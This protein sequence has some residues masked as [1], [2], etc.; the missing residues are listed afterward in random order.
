VVVVP[1]PVVVAA[2]KAGAL[3]C[4]SSVLRSLAFQDSALEDRIL[5]ATTI[6]GMVR[7]RVAVWFSSR[8]SEGAQSVYQEVQ[9][10]TKMLNQG[11][12]A[13]AR[14]RTFAAEIGGHRHHGV[15]SM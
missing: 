2:C 9:K 12:L 7:G 6:H 5:Y 3:Q 14:Q 4:V 1:Q 13:L 10:E 8:G 15:Y 11:A